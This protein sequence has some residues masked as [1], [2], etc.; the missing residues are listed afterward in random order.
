MQ[1]QPTASSKPASA[2]VRRL[3]TI[4]LAIVAASSA[5][6]ALLWWHAGQ[7]PRRFAIVDAGR[8]YRSGEVTP[9]HLARLHHEYGIRRVISLLDPTAA[10]TRAEREAAQTLGLEWHNVP[11]PG[12]G[13]STPRQRDL[14]R[15][16][17]AQPDS[18]PTLVHCAAGVNRTGLAV[19]MYR[20]HCQGWSLAQVMAELRANDFEDLP[21]HQN[22]RDA[23]QAEAQL[24][25][26]A[27][28]PA[29]HLP[30]AEVPGLPE[31]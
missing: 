11:L 20:L 12:D 21:K 16:L 30:D 15:A 28:A 3:T 26:Q 27:A 8:L 29:A 2:N 7:W 31:P 23:L 13:A 17:L 14:L 22:L 10:V 18:P 9:Q 4:L 19:G 5:G 25:E 1:T 24:A 6:G